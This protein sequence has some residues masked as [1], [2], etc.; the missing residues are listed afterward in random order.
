MMISE[1]GMHTN[2]DK[3]NVPEGL[4]MLTTIHDL[5]RITPSSRVHSRARN[6]DSH[7][8]QPTPPELAVGGKRP[9][10]TDARYRNSFAQIHDDNGWDQILEALSYDDQLRSDVGRNFAAFQL[11]LKELLTTIV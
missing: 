9:C 2:H 6:R 10:R 4:L 1:H 5:K 3:L 8:R 7:R 11:V